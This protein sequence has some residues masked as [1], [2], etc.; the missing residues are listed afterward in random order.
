MRRRME[1]ARLA[2]EPRRPV[3]PGIQTHLDPRLANTGTTSLPDDLLK[4]QSVRMQLLYAIGTILW[5]INFGF[6]TYIAPHGD[7][8]PYAA[9]IEVAA[10]LLA[11]GAALHARYGTASHG[12]KVN[13]GIVSLVLHAL[14][15]ALLNSWTEQPTTMRPVS[16]ITVL[17]LF[18]GMMA[19]ANPKRMLIGALTAASMDPLCVWFAHLRGLPVPS[20]LHTMIMFFPNYSCA[21]LAV[22]PARILYRLGRNLRA[23]RALGSYQLIERLGDGGMG[24]VW[25]AHHRLL[26]RTAAIKLVRPDKLGELGSDDATVTLARFEREARATAALTSPH[27]IRVFDFGLTDDGAFYYVMELLDGRDL[28]SFVRQFGPL[29]PARA[30]YILRQ[31]CRSLAEAHTRGLIHRDVK[32]ANI[33]LCRMGL[34]FDYV[35]VLDFGL[36]KLERPGEAVTM[37][38]AAPAA[39][40]TPAYMAPETILADAEVDRR[41][42][43]YALGCVA[44]FLLTGERVF[45]G[46]TQMK[47]LMQH[48]Q[49]R[50]V[51]PSRRTGHRVSRALD[52]LILECLRK[53]PN[54]RPAD[55]DTVFERLSDCAADSW[56]QVDAR[57]WWEEHL[58]QIA[59]PVTPNLSQVAA[60]RA[61]C[62]DADRLSMGTL[63]RDSQ[64]RT[65]C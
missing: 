54:Q 20:P 18:F 63:N 50:P 49:E 31:V 9:L 23:A 60:P 15:I 5:T 61:M 3:E 55:A 32:P 27:T 2:I 56:H 36:V 19:P 40:G 39:M 30:V 16:G 14:A 62:A 48:L 37:M 46:N 4:E 6:D 7:R 10:I 51:P 35:K 47:L 28:E 64:M 58:P 45:D 25:R 43:V 22:V 34:E 44:Y 29:S 24:E 59:H 11:A 33:Y 41:V 53:D 8:G 17:I 38:T 52:D 1:S 12:L 65:F 26:A 21:V 42:D 13:L 57:R